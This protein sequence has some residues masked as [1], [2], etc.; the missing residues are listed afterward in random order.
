LPEQIGH[1][2]HTPPP[3]RLELV[4]DLSRPGYGIA[5]GAHQ[6]LPSV[7]LLADQTGSLQHCD[8]FLYCGET[9]RV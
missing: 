1:S 8:V 7:T 4:E 5:V 3:H 6:P 9:D 2:A